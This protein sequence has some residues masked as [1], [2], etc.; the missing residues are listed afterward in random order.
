MSK[1][2]V[3]LVIFIISIIFIV[4]FQSSIGFLLH[5]SAPFVLVLLQLIIC[6]LSYYFDHSSEINKWKYYFYS[7]FR[8]FVLLI[9]GY[10]G[11]GLALT[12]YTDFNGQ[13]GIENLIAFDIICYFQLGLLTTLILY[14]SVNFRKRYL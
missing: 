8:N 5:Q 9:L 10:I 1:K 12:I 11:L 3:Y 2:Y 4:N 7:T 6:Y 13:G 14:E